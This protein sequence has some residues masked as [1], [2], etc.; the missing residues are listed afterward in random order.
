MKVLDIDLDFFLSN[1]CLSPHDNNR[2]AASEF[3]P[4]APE[5]V[6]KFM[7]HNCGL[8]TSPQLP[9]M[10]VTTHDEVFDI[11]KEQV[12][13]R[14]LLAPFDVVHIDA[15]ADLGLGDSSYVYILGELLHAAP[16]E[17]QEPTRGGSSGL[18]EGNYL[19]FAIACR[20]LQTLTYVHHPLMRDDLPRFLF[21]GHDPE[22]KIIEFGCYRAE[23]ARRLAFRET[24]PQALAM[25]PQVPIRV[26]AKEDFIGDHGEFVF[27]YVSI[28]PRYTPS[29]AEAIMPIIGQYL[30]FLDRVSF[31]QIGRGCEFTP[32]Q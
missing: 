2:P 1:I 6:R 8:T 20:W 14:Q 16:H 31:L 25:E 24:P 7:E 4:W 10:K 13:T 12:R 23:D 27:G 32:N 19:A 17:R 15:H 30:Q 18:N 9:A 26:I 22:T 11:W 29:E 5:A 21:R 3:C 28:S